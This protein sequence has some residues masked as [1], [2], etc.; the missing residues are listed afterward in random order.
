MTK[1]IR[2]VNK[3]LGYETALIFLVFVFGLVFSPADFWV[4]LFL[5]LLP[6]LKVPGAVWVLNKC[7]LD[8]KTGR[9]AG[10]LGYC[11]WVIPNWELSSSPCC[12]QCTMLACERRVFFWLPS[13]GVRVKVREWTL[14]A[15]ARRRSS[16]HVTGTPILPFWP[17]VCESSPMEFTTSDNSLNTGWHPPGRMGHLSTEPEGGW[18]FTCVDKH[19]VRLKVRLAQQIWSNLIGT[20]A[21]DRLRP[22]KE[23]CHSAK[24][25][26]QSDFKS[27]V[28]PFSYQNTFRV[29]VGKS[30][31]WTLMSKFLVSEEKVPCWLNRNV[32]DKSCY[33][34]KSKFVWI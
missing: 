6:R 31:F 1:N 8:P 30:C 28:C 16:R 26:N 12:F 29:L 2:C 23:C 17:S 34:Y 13:S 10:F 4:P 27:T 9:A 5:P 33:G 14:R 20:G 15:C 7:L 22:I 11:K 18:R 25:D 3:W 32:T 24:A 19:V 21:D